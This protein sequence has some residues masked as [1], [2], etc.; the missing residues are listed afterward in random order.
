MN[1][2]LRVG[3]VTAALSFALP[4]AA[5]AQYTGVS[6][7]DQTPITNAPE[8]AAA[9]PAADL[10]PETSAPVLKPR[11]GI[12]MEAAPA[13]SAAQRSTEPTASLHSP[14]SPIDP[15]AGIVTRLPGPANELPVGTM[16][17]V[18]LNQSI[19]TQ[20]TANGTVFT[21]RLV[22]PVVRD[23]RVLLPVG[24]M[25][26]GLVTDVHGGKRISGAASLHLRTETVTL[27][28]GTQYRLRGQVID[29]S[30]Y[31]AVKVDD[32]GTILRRDHGGK[33]AS[34]MALAAGSGAAAGAMVAGVPGAVIGAAAGVGVGT[35]VWL[36][37]DRQTELPAETKIVFSL[38]APLVTGTDDLHGEPPTRPQPEAE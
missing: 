30:L 19:S 18:R 5:V 38:T 1:I 27:P 3:V 9:Q 2:A 13:D 31:N 26:A 28:D 24:A 22:E 17:K 16:V 32:E 14:A 23:G 20:A 7:P 33:T 25:L 21:A 35:A 29:T 11:P 10:V 37:Q 6:H 8:P 4:A 12:P 36:K 15:D 34:V